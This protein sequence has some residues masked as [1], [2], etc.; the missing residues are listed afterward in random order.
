M[1]CKDEFIPA[2]LVFLSSDTHEGTCYIETMNL[3]GETNL[4][5]KRAPDVTKDFGAQTLC[6]ISGQVN[7]EG[8]N[9]RLYSYVGN[10]VLD[11]PGTSDK[12]TVPLDP[13]SIL[14]RGCSLR[15]TE[16]IYGLV[17]Y[18]GEP[19]LRDGVSTIKI[20]GFPVPAQ[21]SH[22]NCWFLHPTPGHDKTLCMD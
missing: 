7:C 12:V 5:I 14:L 9:A 21:F 20:V 16:K 10:L 22:P 13:T 17:V 1:V 3:D 2:D 6:L 15:N 8:P 18:A 4:K 19:G 11:V